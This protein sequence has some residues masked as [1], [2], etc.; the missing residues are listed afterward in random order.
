MQS[1]KLL[2][3]DIFERLQI[4]TPLGFLDGSSATNMHLRCVHACFRRL[5]CYDDIVSTK[6]TVAIR[7]LCYPHQTSCCYLFAWNRQSH[8]GGES[9][10]VHLQNLYHRFWKSGIHVYF[11]SAMY[12]E[13]HRQHFTFIPFPPSSGFQSTLSTPLLVLPVV[14]KHS[15]T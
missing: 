3:P 14:G 13:T 11:Q 9:G 6:K 8:A 5:I 7:Q 12:F 1:S 2:R 4:R 10:G 15:H